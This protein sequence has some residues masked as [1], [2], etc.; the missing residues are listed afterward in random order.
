MA[1]FCIADGASEFHAT[2]ELNDFWANTETQYRLLEE[3]SQRLTELFRADRCRLVWKRFFVS[4]AIN[5]AVHLKTIENE[6]L[7]VVQQPPLNGS[8]AS[9]LLYFVE[10]VQLTI[11]ADNTVVMKRPH[12]EHL[13]HNQLHERTGN[14][15]S[16]TRSIFDRYC[17][18]LSKRGC[19]LAK[20]CIRTWIFVQNVDTQYAEMVV[21]RRECFE[22]EE[23]TPQTHYI[24]STGIEGRY[25]HP[26][27]LILMDA[28]AIVNV[29]PEQIRYLHA[30]THLNP[31]H[32]YGVTFERGTAVDYGDRRHVFISGTASINNRGEIVHPL[33]IEKQ[34]A[35]TFENVQALLAE[36]GATMQHVAH[37]VI[38]LRDTADYAVTNRYI[39]QYYPNIP[40]VMLWAPVCRPGWLIEIECMAIITT[41]N[42]QF[43]KF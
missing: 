9:L 24:A 15:A 3:A 33:D 11:E 5:H 18:N 23:L 16:Q 30:P 35:R 19:S 32:E 8:K 10:N 13:F 1:K 14:A 26:E 36:A 37:M 28:Y 39:A 31:T 29:Q 41:E 38:Y 6:A 42:Q 25:I 7:S 43:E 40:C 12:Y 22:R 27:T 2:I 4:D 21:A 17:N 34:I 20:N